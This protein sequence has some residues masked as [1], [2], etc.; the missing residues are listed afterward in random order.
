MQ[1]SSGALTSSASRFACGELFFGNNFFMCAYL[2]EL[3]R[4]FK[5]PTFNSNT[6]V[7]SSLISVLTHDIMSTSGYFSCNCS[8]I[9]FTFGVMDDAANILGTIVDI[10]KI[11]EFE[12]QYI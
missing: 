1:K 4:T 9:P 11:I 12:F 10:Y 7:L 2:R 5:S 3:R 8:R 6:F